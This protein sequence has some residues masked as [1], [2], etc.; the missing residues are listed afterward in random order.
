MGVSR[1]RRVVDDVEE[2]LALGRPLNSQLSSELRGDA[3]ADET[4]DAPLLLQPSIDAREPGSRC[5]KRNE[6]ERCA[7]TTRRA[8]AARRKVSTRG[9]NDAGLSVVVGEGARVEQD[10][11]ERRSGKSAVDADAEFVS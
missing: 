9:E 6:L 8:A 3:E 2:L 10:H 5:A 7:R 11:C 1:R 4:E